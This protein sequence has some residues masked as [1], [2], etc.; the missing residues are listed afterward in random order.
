[1]RLYTQ[2]HRFFCGIDLHART[3]FP[4]ARRDGSAAARTMPKL[5]VAE[6]TDEFKKENSLPLRARPS[7]TRA[8]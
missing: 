4:D 7:T 5:P 3:L 8:I 1:M 6:A 2:P